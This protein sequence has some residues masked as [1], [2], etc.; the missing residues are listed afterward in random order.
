MFHEK[1]SFWQGHD[2]YNLI[3][4]LNLAAMWRIDHSVGHQRV[5]GEESRSSYETWSWSMDQ[6]QLW[7]GKEVEKQRNMGIFCKLS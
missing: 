3:Y 6:G 7:R 4:V 1:G 2:M 5:A